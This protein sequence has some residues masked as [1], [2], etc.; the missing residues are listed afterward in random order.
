[1]TNHKKYLLV[2]LII[3]THISLLDLFFVTLSGPV[4][5][6]EENLRSSTIL[7]HLLI[8][9]SSAVICFLTVQL[10]KAYKSGKL[11]LR[12]NVLMLCSLCLAVSIYFVLF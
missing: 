3:F 12:D 6:V 4:F 11:K 1:M 7:T 8:A 5:L 2:F 9:T 10:R